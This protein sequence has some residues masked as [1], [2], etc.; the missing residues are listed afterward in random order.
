M[1]QICVTHAHREQDVLISIKS[2]GGMHRQTARLFH[3]LPFNFHNK[4]SRLR[5]SSYLTENTLRLYYKD[6][7][8]WGISTRIPGSYLTLSHDRLFP[9]SFYITTLVSFNH[10]TLW[11]DFTNS[12]CGS[13]A[14]GT[15]VTFS[16]S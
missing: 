9:S 1:K 4:G 3:K 10:L 8:D 12:L 15:L 13:T 14:L 2:Y 16:V 7:T 11:C 5:L 6:Y